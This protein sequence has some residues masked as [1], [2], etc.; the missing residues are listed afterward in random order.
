MGPDGRELARITAGG[1]DRM[2]RGSLALDVPVPAAGAAAPAI[3]RLR[4]LLD[5]LWA[6]VPVLLALAGALR[7]RA[8][9]RKSDA[10]GNP[11][12]ASG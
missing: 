7:G 3:A 6:G 4:R 11:A 2:V 1:S 8:A 10:S 12:P 5:G 9:S